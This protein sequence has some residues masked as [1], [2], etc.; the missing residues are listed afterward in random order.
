MTHNTNPL[1]PHSQASVPSSRTFIS[2][3][4]PLPHHQVETIKRSAVLVHWLGVEQLTEDCVKLAN[5]LWRTGIPA[6]LYYTTVRGGLRAPPSVLLL[7]ADALTLL[8]HRCR[9]TR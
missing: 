2:P 5:S 6:Q 4:S 3:L 7:A 1:P 9:W 8:P